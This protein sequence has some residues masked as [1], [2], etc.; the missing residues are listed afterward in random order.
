[1][2]VQPTVDIGK[3]VAQYVK[4]RDKI[5]ELDD[6]HKKN[7]A[8]YRELLE[9]LNGALLSHLTAQNSESIKTESGTVYRTERAS[10]SLA[11]K[12]AFWAWVVAQGEWDL[13]DYKA[14][15]TAVRDFIDRNNRPPPGVN[16][17]VAHVVGVRRA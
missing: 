1:M 3:R 4:L 14:N 10:A 12:S 9:T 11:D 2:N 5:K 6:I 8:P 7:T 16:Y 13:L 17:T 15:S